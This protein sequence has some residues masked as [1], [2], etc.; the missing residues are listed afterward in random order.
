MSGDVPPPFVVVPRAVVPHAASPLFTRDAGPL[1][2]MP[3]GMQGVDP[4]RRSPPSS[5]FLVLQR[6]GHARSSICPL[7]W[8]EAHQD[9]T[10]EGRVVWS[11]FQIIHNLR[12][13]LIRCTSLPTY[14]RLDFISSY[15][16]S[17]HTVSAV[18]LASDIR[19]AL[20]KRI[21][22]KR[23]DPIWFQHYSVIIL[24]DSIWPLYHRD[25]TRRTGK[26]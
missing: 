5:S 3:R 25:G 13:I 6:E 17:R 1:V 12:L 9:Y 23:D 20:S 8:E 2:R 14:F 19:V 26:L 4:R 24:T 16:L 18:N 21:F 15:L 7:G 11:P 10:Q 22:S